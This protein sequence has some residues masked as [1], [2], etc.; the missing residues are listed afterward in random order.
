MAPELPDASLFHVA[1]GI[2]VRWGDLDALAHVNNA[3]YFTYFESARIAWFAHMMPGHAV[4]L[5]GV[6]P[7]VLETR[8]RFLTPIGFP[9]SVR[10]GTRAVKAGTTSLEMEY[11]V[12]D[13]ETGEAYAIGSAVLVMYDY[14]A[15][16]KVPIPDDLRRRMEVL[17]GIG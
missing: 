2:D 5:Q 3:T 10:V 13:R 1:V 12:T 16:T 11:L 7:I 8:C 17:E 9:A 6:G 14:R 15:Q 4:S